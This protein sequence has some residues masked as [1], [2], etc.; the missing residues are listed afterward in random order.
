VS[1][2]RLRAPL[3][4]GLVWLLGAV[5]ATSVGVLAVRQVAAQVGDPAVPPVTTQTAPARTTPPTTPPVTAP[6]AQATAAPTAT[7][8]FTSPAGTL[9]AQ[10]AGT[11]ARLLY[12]TPADGYAV[13]EQS[14]SGSELEVRFEGRGVRV[15]TSVSC[16]SGRPELLEQRTDERN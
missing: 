5:V 11:T 10:C 16:A 1:T 4:L 15:R 8:T 14:V 7:R 12:A 6:G 2:S 3:L 9:G 13:D